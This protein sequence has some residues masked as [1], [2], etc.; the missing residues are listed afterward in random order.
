L[1]G[2]FK[3]KCMD[4]VLLNIVKFTQHQL[5]IVR[6]SINVTNKLVHPPSL[7]PKTFMEEKVAERNAIDLIENENSFT[8]NSF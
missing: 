5:K 7:S 3:R 2:D 1:P 6:L 4:K 8:E